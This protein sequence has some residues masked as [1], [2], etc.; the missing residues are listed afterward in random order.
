MQTLLF[1][2]VRISLLFSVFIFCGCT[3]YVFDPQYYK[4]RKYSK[5][6]SGTYVLNKALYDEIMQKQKD[7]KDTK[8]ENLKLEEKI[9]SQIKHNKNELWLQKREHY[10]KLAYKHSGY[11]SEK[12]AQRLFVLDVINSQKDRILSNGYA[13]YSGAYSTDIAVEIPQSLRE[14]IGGLTDRNMKFQQ[15][16][17]PQFFYIDDNGKAHIISLGILYRYVN[18]N[19]VYGLKEDS[20]I[21]SVFANGEWLYLRKNKVRYVDFE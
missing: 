16:I 17:Y 12:N 7:S 20:N 19:R 10:L 14:K 5:E 11:Y 21:E 4:A 13:Y 18:I 15:I 8:A 9:Y 2:S 6:Y 1:Y 3:F